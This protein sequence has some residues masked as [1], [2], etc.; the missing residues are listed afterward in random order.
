MRRLIRLAVLLLLACAAAPAM[1][2]RVALVVGAGAYRHAPPLPNAT[3]DASDLAAMLRDLGFR[4]DLVLDPDRAAMEQAVERFGVAARGAEAALFFYAG[5]AIEVQGRNW[6][7]PVSAELRTPQQLRFQAL[8]LEAV[9]EQIQQVARFSLIILDACRDNPFRQRWPAASRSAAG[10]GLARISPA[11]GTLVVFSTAPGAVAEDGRGRNSPFTSALLRHLPTPGLEV[12]ALFAEVRRSVREAT[13]GAQVPWE[14]SSLEGNFY[15]RAAAPAAPPPPPPQA[16][17]PAPVQTPAPIFVLPQVPATPGHD[18]LAWQYVMNSRNPADFESF[19]E[20]FPDSVFAPFARNR[21]AELRGP[22]ERGIVTAPQPAPAPAPQIAALPAP[23]PAEPPPDPNR[24]L[25]RAEVQE[26]QRLL[27]GMGFDAGPPDGLVG[28]RSREALEAFALAADL[29][30]STQFTLGTLE[31]L[32]GPAPSAERRRAALAALAPPPAP[33]ATPATPAP[34]VARPAPPAVAPTPSPPAVPAG[35]VPFRCPPAGMRLVM[36]DGPTQN[37]R[38]TAPDDPEVCLYGDAANPMRALFGLI[39]LPFE[40]ERRRRDGMRA[41]FPAAPGR[42]STFIY[43]EAV[44]GWSTSLRDTWE[45]LRR[46]TIQLESGP[47]ATLVIRRERRGEFGNL[48][49]SQETYWWDIATGA[50]LRRDVQLIRGIGA[51]Q[52]F[53]AVRI[54]GG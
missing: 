38:G 54:E 52:P 11:V 27:S 15:F 8:E 24:P 1:A 23:R 51:N 39:T 45:V 13:G 14:E 32:R 46:E 16:A 47:R 33:P 53:R 3:N 42:S 2:E 37:F 19:I 18:V 34:V 43:V 29:P 36:E 49:L 5:H 30:A 44:R 41:I 50:W 9:T 40:D 4:V 48:H 17:A 20:Q 12:R 28:P 21:L 7:I 22:P 35:P 25:T 26:A 31:R 6:I 10:R